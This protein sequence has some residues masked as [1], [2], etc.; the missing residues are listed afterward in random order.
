MDLGS[1][2]DEKLE[3]DFMDDVKPGDKSVKRIAVFKKQ[4]SKGVHDMQV[5]F[6]F[7]WFFLNVQC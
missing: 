4:I 6:F 5:Q 3:T 1:L 2:V 7:A